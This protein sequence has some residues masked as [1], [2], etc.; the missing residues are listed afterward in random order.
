MLESTL[1]QPQ[2]LTNAR[3]VYIIRVVDDLI[4]LFKA[5]TLELSGIL[6]HVIKHNISLYLLAI[7]TQVLELVLVNTHK[8]LI[9]CVAYEVVYSDVELIVVYSD[10]LEHGC[11]L[12]HLKVDVLVNQCKHLSNTISILYQQ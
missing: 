12:H 5:S 9:I 8:H 3:H 2:L 4:N 7:C 1:C 11:N 10:Q 6:I